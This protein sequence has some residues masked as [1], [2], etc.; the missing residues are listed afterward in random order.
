[1]KTLQKFETYSDEKCIM[2]IKHVTYLCIKNYLSR[3]KFSSQALKL[4][5]SKC[6]TTPEI[7]LICTYQENGNIL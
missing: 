7:S 5:F 3:H 2:M 1:M 6:K 4:A